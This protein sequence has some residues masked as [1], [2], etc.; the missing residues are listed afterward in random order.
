[1]PRRGYFG[2][3]KG[4]YTF[5]EYL[6]SGLSQPFYSVFQM[7]LLEEEDEP[8]AS[9]NKNGVVL[10]LVGPEPQSPTG[11]GHGH[12]SKE[13]EATRSL[14]MYKLSSLTSLA[15]WAISQKVSLCKS[16]CLHLSNSS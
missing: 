16:S 15:R 14:R 7:T 6:M 4:L 8:S 2:L 10:C 1:M 9:S 13:S 11:H 12:G 3:G 5:C